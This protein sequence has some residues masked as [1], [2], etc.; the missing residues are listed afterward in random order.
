MAHAEGALNDPNTQ[1]HNCP[2]HM[3]DADLCPCIQYNHINGGDPA[4][5]ILNT[6]VWSVGSAI[7]AGLPTSG[8]V[9]GTGVVG[10]PNVQ[11]FLNYQYTMYHDPGVLSGCTWFQW[12]VQDLQQQQVQSGW[13]PTNSNFIRLQSKIDWLLC[14]FDKCCLS[15]TAPSSGPLAKKLS[16]K[17]E[18]QFN[19]A[20]GFMNEEDDIK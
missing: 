16:P 1:R 19:N 12:R 15:D 11:P 10:Q 4:Y 18:F 17:E 2:P 20:V 9:T 14:M 3:F 7:A 8:G 5:N 13:G 6:I